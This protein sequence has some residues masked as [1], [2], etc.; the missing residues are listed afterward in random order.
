MR[1]DTFGDDEQRQRLLPG[2]CS[3]D[4]FASYCLTEPGSGSDAA[5]LSTKAV[6]DGDHLVLNGSK[7]FLS[8]GGASDVYVVMCRTGAAGPRGISCV[9]V[10]AGTPG[11]SFGKQERKRGWNSQPTSAVM[12]EDCRVPVRNLI[13]TEGDGFKY[14]MQ[15]LDGGRLSIATCSIG[16][17]KASYDLARAHV[18]DRKQF[19][20]PLA[21]NQSV[22]FK[23]A[24][25]TTDIHSARLMVRHAA[26]MMDD[27]DPNATPYCAMAKRVA[28]DA[29]FNVCNE[30]LQLH[31]GYGYL[32]DYALSRYLRDCRVHQILEGTNEIMRHIVAR[33]VLAD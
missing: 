22:Q 26:R 14:A 6:R 24:D 21:A 30:A 8:G 18:Q 27:K 31:G 3:M 32:E 16:A 13:G 9:V 10:E 4:Q 2:L 5:S 12:F 15:G 19:G 23:L 28:T 29:G 20:N 33:S 17:A 11:L 7:A 25:M 1:I